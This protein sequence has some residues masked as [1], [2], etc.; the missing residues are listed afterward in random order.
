[1]LSLQMGSWK[2]LGYAQFYVSLDTYEYGSSRSLYSI[3]ELIDFEL[4]DS[5]VLTTEDIPIVAERIPVLV[6]GGRLVQYY[7][8][9]N[10]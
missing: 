5:M 3:G 6:Y 2:K 9:Y 1:M 4:I 10:K 7:H 8:N